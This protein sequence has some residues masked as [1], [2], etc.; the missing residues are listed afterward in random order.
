VLVKTRKVAGILLEASGRAVVCGIGINVNQT[1]SELPPTPRTPATSLLIEAGRSFNR[2]V[3]LAS[4]LNEL[5]CRYSAWV[6]SG[7]SCLSDEIAHRNAI[8]GR[9]LRVGGHTGT[10]GE[11]TADG[12]LTMVL[13]NGETVLVGTGEVESC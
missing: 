3:V 1:A 13:D 8:R 5:E 7:L 6:T 4:V 9:R 2:G 12:R 11:I 10:G